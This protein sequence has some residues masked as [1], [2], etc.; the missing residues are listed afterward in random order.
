MRV[1]QQIGLKI[2]CKCLLES[3]SQHAEHVQLVACGVNI[4][5]SISACKL[6][7]PYLIERFQSLLDPRPQRF[8]NSL[9]VYQVSLCFMHRPRP[10]EP[11]RALYSS[12]VVVLHLIG[13]TSYGSL[14]RIIIKATKDIRNTKKFK[15]IE[16]YHIHWLVCPVSTRT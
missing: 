6:R 15:L 3:S 8:S 13:R 5:S 2:K 10:P 14:D 16:F 9:G 12:A 1:H 11:N 4:P 7:P